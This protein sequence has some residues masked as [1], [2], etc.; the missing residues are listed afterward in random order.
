MMMALP[1]C[2]YRALFCIVAATDDRLY[3]PCFGRFPHRVTA[4]SQPGNDVAENG[5]FP[6]L[7]PG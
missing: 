2:C 1:V 7:P 3:Q 5:I 6:S 4:V